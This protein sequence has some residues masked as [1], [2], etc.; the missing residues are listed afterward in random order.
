MKKY[1]DMPNSKMVAMLDWKE[2]HGTLEEAK[3]YLSSDKDVRE[4][5]KKEFDYL[6]EK[7]SNN[8]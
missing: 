3:E 4:I 8:K 1:Y 6:G 7:Y 5:T 2:G